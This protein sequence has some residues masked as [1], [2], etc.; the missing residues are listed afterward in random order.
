[1]DG[2]RKAGKNANEGKK[3]EKIMRLRGWNHML[4]AG[5]VAL[6]AGCDGP[7][8]IDPDAG[9]L[10]FDYYGAEQG[11]YTARG[12][13]P[14][15]GESPLGRRFAVGYALP[16]EVRVSAFRAIADQRSHTI[17]ILLQGAVE[18]GAEVA[19][20]CSGV[21]DGT[22]CFEGAVGLRI[23]PA[24]PADDRSSAATSPERPASIYGFDAG[25]VVVETVT[26]DRIT[27]TFQ[28]TASGAD[29]TIEVRDGRFD[30]PRLPV[31]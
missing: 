20:T 5:L 12:V 14:G 16:G 11:A 27:G 21:T 19:T 15:P 2:G 18:P 1:M 28:G 25:R 24:N 7:T 23:P 4:A 3:E 26:P 10:S 29:G 8:E 31:Q 17:T 13:P 30:V 6:A 9:T 22:P